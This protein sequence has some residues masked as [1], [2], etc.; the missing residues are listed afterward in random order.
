MYVEVVV[1]NPNADAN[2][3]HVVGG[4]N[5]ACHRYLRLGALDFSTLVACHGQSEEECVVCLVKSSVTDPLDKSK[6]ILFDF[7]K[8][9]DCVCRGLFWLLFSDMKWQVLMQ[10]PT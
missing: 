2:C 10:N 8:H 5:V 6:N 9:R 1:A 3:I 4:T 7:K